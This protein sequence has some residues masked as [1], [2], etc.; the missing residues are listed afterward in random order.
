[1][2]AG[3]SPGAWWL[4]KS[5]LDGGLDPAG[6]LNELIVP[7]LRSI[8]ERWASGEVS[9]ADEHRATAVAQRLIGHLGLQF[10]RRGK[11]RGAVA[12]AAPSG[13]LHML[14]IAIVADLL[15]WHA[16]DVL[17][18]GA[19]TP[20]DALADAVAASGP[21]AWPSASSRPRQGWKPKWP[22]RC[23]SVRTAVPDVPIFL[24]GPGIRSEA[25][26]LELGGDVWT[27]VG[28]DAAVETVERIAGSFRERSRQQCRL[29]RSSA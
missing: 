28:A 6:I 18:L 20:A 9:V 22:H 19:N 14:P 4:V 7:A 5:Q 2:L 11:S 23:A 27:G 25:H 3:D 15:R 16:F 12:L 1:M 26:A 29:K 10:G 8:G 17:E 24:G 21:P 13:D